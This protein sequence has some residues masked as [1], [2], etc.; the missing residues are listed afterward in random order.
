ML[1]LK[2][3]ALEKSPYEKVH[4]SAGTLPQKTRQPLIDFASVFPRPVSNQQFGDSQQRLRSFSPFATTTQT[5]RF[6]LA[7]RETG[8]FQKP[9]DCQDNSN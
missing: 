7:G 4:G 3:I 5:R 1:F 2:P 8:F 9:V 6:S